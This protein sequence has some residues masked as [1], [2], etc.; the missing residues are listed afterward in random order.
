VVVRQSTSE[1]P[2]KEQ[3]SQQEVSSNQP[4]ASVETSKKLLQQLRQIRD[5]RQGSNQEK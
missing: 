5:Q 1:S 4:S 3:T 2:T